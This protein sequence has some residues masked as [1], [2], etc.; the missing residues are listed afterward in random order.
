MDIS[1]SYYLMLYLRRRIGIDPVNHLSDS[2]P[3]GQIRKYL[4]DTTLIRKWRFLKHR[5]IL[6]HPVMNDI[7][8][9]LIYKVNLSA[10]KIGVV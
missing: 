6:H 4:Y 1:L 3:H 9:D 5:Q 7:L 8:N 10:V 2:H